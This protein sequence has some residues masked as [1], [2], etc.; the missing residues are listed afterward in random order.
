MKRFALPAWVC[1]LAVWLPIGAWSG[2]AETRA[3]TISVSGTAVS[4]APVDTVPWTVVV[5]TSHK[6]LSPLSESQRA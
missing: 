4:Y 2:E 1:M 6:D 3:R 5:E